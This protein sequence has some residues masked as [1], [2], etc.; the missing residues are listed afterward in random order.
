MVTS[1]TASTD[2]GTVD[3]SRVTGTPVASSASGL[4][5]MASRTL[6]TRRRTAAGSPSGSRGTLIVTPRARP[7]SR[8]GLRGSEGACSA[9]HTCLLL[10]LSRRLRSGPPPNSRRAAQAFVSAASQRAQQLLRY[11]RLWPIKRRFPESEKDEWAQK[12]FLSIQKWGGAPFAAVFSPFLGPSG[13]YIIC[14]PPFV[15]R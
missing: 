2:A 9:R 11:F 5:T 12:K 6:R 10:E 14:G 15:P 1:S 7:Q 13:K 8:R 3:G 4:R